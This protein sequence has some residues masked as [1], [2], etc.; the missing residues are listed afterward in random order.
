MSVQRAFE[1]LKA[2]QKAYNTYWAY[3]DGDHPLVYSTAR[4]REVFKGLDARFVENW[5]SVVINVPVERLL[6]ESITVANDATATEA[7][8]SLWTGL[9]MHL[10]ADDAH[11]AALVC[12]EAFVM[13]WPDEAGAVQ[14][15]YN[16]P[17]KCH[18]FYDEDNP[19]AKSLG[20]KWWTAGDGTHRMT[21][22]YRD[23]LEYYG[24]SKANEQ[25]TSYKAFVKIAEDEVNP[26]GVIPI[27]HLR[28]ERRAIISE[29]D[30]AIPLQAAINKLLADEMISAE[31][32]AFRQRYVIS[33]ADVGNLKNAPNEVWDLPAGDGMGQQT[34]AGE[35]SAT[36]LGNFETAIERRIAALSAITRI[37][38]HYFFRLGG[39]PPSGEA[40]IA[41]ESPLLKKVDRYIKRFTS[42]WQAIAAF[43]LAL[44]GRQVARQDIEPQYADPA[45]VQPRTEAEVRQTNTNAGVP[46]VTTVRRQGWSEA[47]IEEMRQDRIEEQ[48]DAQESLAQAL[49]EQQRRFDQGVGESA[50]QA[51]TEQ[52]E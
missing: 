33:N 6:L 48:A 31:F 29:L 5:C 23:R 38:P 13:V 7:L 22:Y 32:G 15:Y 46:I 37:P 8:R 28:P 1:A 10:D 40:L 11:L 39:Q 21:L 43:M 51:L 41:L 14:A 3:Y 20:A 27:F 24:T 16:D 35:F 2:K 18:V 49:I 12:G 9:D 17:R 45:T 42:T 50:N 25:P 47:E 34:S 44:D 26:Y 52:E 36:E 4:L 30:N 19:R